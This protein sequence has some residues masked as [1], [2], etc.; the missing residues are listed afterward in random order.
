[1][2]PKFLGLEEILRIHDA[3]KRTGANA[4]NVF[5]TMNDL[6]LS[7]DDKEYEK[8]VLEAATGKLSKEGVA[9]CFRKT[10]R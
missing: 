9:E 4:A 2:P 7:A 1:M 3:N 8:L 6:E 5:L 10:C